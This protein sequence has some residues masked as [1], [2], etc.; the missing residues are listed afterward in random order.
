[1]RRGCCSRAWAG[2]AE[3]AA[4]R[5][6]IAPHES[7]LA[8]NRRM[9]PSRPASHRFR[10]TQENCLPRFVE[11]RVVGGLGTRHGV[12]GFFDGP[13]QRVALNTSRSPT[14]KGPFFGPAVLAAATSVDPRPSVLPHLGAKN[15][16]LAGARFSEREVDLP[17]E[18]G[19]RVPLQSDWR[20]RARLAL[21]I[22]F[23]VWLGQ[24]SPAIRPP[25]RHP[26]GDC[27]KATHK[28]TKQMPAKGAKAVVLSLQNRLEPSFDVC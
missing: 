10:S 15:E 12:E 24:P 17:H 9:Q 19:A 20:F 6:T 18:L 22:G 3:C 14:L 16:V 4:T 25:Y 27:R 28:R 7:V 2:G 11:R 5:R 13:S 26:A 1:M 8:G 23:G 21:I